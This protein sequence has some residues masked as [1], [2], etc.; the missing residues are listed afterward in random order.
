[1]DNDTKLCPFCAE[2]IKTAAIVCRYC[3]R[4]LV[5]SPRITASP[6]PERPQPRQGGPSALLVLFAVVG[7]LALIAIGVRSL[8]QTAGP[9]RV[10]RSSEL[11][12]QRDG[13]VQCTGYVG[14]NP[15]IHRKRERISPPIGPPR[16]S[17]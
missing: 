2:T 15:P 5:N 13:F 4:D 10:Q 14:A 7:A 11:V 3:G 6:S 12:T 1:M 17:T 8:G 16:G 9:I